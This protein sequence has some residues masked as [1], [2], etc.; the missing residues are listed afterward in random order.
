MLPGKCEQSWLN[1]VIDV[2]LVIIF[3]LSIGQQC[4]VEFRVLEAQ[5]LDSYWLKDF[6]DGTPTVGKTYKYSA[7][8]SLLLRHLKR[9]NSLL[10]LL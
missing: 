3:G 6:T 8:H 2:Y 10:S 9:A 5:A 1:N 7:M 4:L